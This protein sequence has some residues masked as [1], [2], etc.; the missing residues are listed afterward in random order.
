[1]C[2]DSGRGFR[3]ICTVTHPILLSSKVET[4]VRILLWHYCQDVLAF[5]LLQLYT[6]KQ[7]WSCTAC[8]FHLFDE[9]FLMMLCISQC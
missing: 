6:V 9:M 3:F 2:N 5:S 1:M 8:I 4:V 7:S